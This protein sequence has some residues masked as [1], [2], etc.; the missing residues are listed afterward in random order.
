M[1]KG[2]FNIASGVINQLTV[3]IM[4]MILPRLFI[5]TFG[6]EVNGMVST[7]NQVFVYFTLFEAGIMTVTIQS[8]YGPV[9][10]GDNAG[11]NG[12]LSASHGYFKQTGYV[13]LVSMV[14]FAAIFPFVVGSD[15]PKVEI[16]SIVLLQGGVGVLNYF[17]Q[18]KYRCLLE[19]QGRMYVLNNLLTFVNLFTN[20]AKIV[21][22]LLGAQIIVVQASY[23]VVSAISLVI[24][25]IYMKRNFDWIDT[26]AKKDVGSISQRKFA[27]V[28]QVST[29]IFNNTDMLVLSIFLGFAVT[30]VYAMYLMLFTM[31]STLVSIVVSGYMYK[32]GHKFNSDKSGYAKLLDCFEQYY[33]SIVFATMAVAYIFVLPFLNIYTEGITDI[34]YIDQYLPIL[35]LAVNLLSSGRVASN[36]TIN[37]AKHF[38]QTKWRTIIESSINLVVSLVAVS[39]WGIYG[40]LFGTVAALLYRTNDM[41]I[42]ANKVVLNRSPLKTY[43]R[44][45]SNLLL[46]GAVL[47]AANYITFPVATYAELLL[48]AGITLFV[49][50]GLFFALAVLTDRKSLRTLKTLI[51]S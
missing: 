27:L 10:K 20:S 30:S 36:A 6:S 51:K 26:N 37:F 43:M 8:L 50:G 14:A 46:L 34:N 19:A 2:L 42:Y 40:V 38:K 11:I 3:V 45:L 47:V 44:W 16:A 28:H 9:A 5:L 15:I 23:F 21:L 32:L 25:K 1:K 41:I 13:Y 35:F 39:I 4:G 31:V 49:V 18:A 17:F 48:S 33:L 7:V 22:I 12:I 24:L 29:L